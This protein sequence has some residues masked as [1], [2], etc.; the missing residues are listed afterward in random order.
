MSKMSMLLNILVIEP[1]ITLFACIDPTHLYINLRRARDVF[2]LSFV[3]LFVCLFVRLASV[4]FGQ[5][6]R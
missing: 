4:H 2:V 5:L 1:K 6:L 3:P